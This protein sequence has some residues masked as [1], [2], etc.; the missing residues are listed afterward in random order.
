MKNLL[1]ILLY[2]S[3]ICLY[4]CIDEIDLIS[5]VPPQ[6]VLVVEGTITNELKTQEII[7]SRSVPLDS[8]VVDIETGATVSVQ[9]SGGNQFNFSQDADG[10]YRSV[11]PF[12]ASFNE[13]YQLTIQTADGRSYES[14]S[15]AL[16]GNSE[17]DALYLEQ[18]FNENGV[19][20][21]NILLDATDNDPNSQFYPQD[22]Y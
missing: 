1:K 3:V 9:T 16:T 15:V 4:G 11:N 18:G 10:V 2:T 21:I 5:E 7:I 20:G 8:G 22:I 13:T 19:E 6:R 14:S 12:A 17:I